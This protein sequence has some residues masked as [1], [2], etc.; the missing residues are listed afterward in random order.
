MPLLPAPDVAKMQPEMKAVA[1]SISIL[2]FSF[3]GWEIVLI[4][5]VLLILLGAERLPE[6]RKGIGDGRHEFRQ[7][8]RNFLR[9]FDDEAGEAGRSLGGIYGKPAAEA[10][11]P[12]N[13]TSELYDPAAFREKEEAPKSASRFLARL[14]RRLWRLVFSHD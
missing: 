2:A 8:L 14:W 10:L 9:R 13:Q 5:S 11:T 3:G 7:A 12:R 4:L 6:L 1:E